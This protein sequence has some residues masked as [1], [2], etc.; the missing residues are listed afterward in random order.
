MTRDQALA[1]IRDAVGPTGWTDAPEDLEPH[2]TEL[3]GL[4]RGRCE[5]LVSP[6][7][8]AETAAVVAACAAAR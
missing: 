8:T 4:W 7:S 1:Q 2:V 3:R 5:M 6:A